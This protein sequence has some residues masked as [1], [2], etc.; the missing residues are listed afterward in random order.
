MTCLFR[1]ALM[2]YA[3]EPWPTDS[4]RA[5]L[6]CVSR[7]GS[8]LFKVWATFL[9]RCSI[10]GPAGLIYRSPF[11]AFTHQSK[12]PNRSSE[13]T[14]TRFRKAG[15]LNSRRAEARQSLFSTDSSPTSNLFRKSERRPLT[16]TR[17]SAV[18]STFTHKGQGH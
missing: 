12:R 15:L 1:L 10:V 5:I 11:N 13:I 3:T 9:R 6:G 7:A 18:C 4:R 17:L 16:V 8:K 14:R 2:I